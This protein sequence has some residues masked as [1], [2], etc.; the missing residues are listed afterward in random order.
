MLR[1]RL[2]L[3]ALSGIMLLATPQV[4]AQSFQHDFRFC[5]GDYALCAASTCPPT[6]GTIAVN[7]ATGTANFPVAECTCPIFNGPAIADL[8]GGNMQGRCEPPPD[9][10]VWSL[11]SPQ[12][13]IP[14]EINDWSKGK[15]QSAAPIF[16]C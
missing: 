9:N 13:H 3:S 15:K 10:G 7:T 12:G 16:V 2:V 5:V 4:R 1:Y 11:Y 8:N 14:Q 6:G